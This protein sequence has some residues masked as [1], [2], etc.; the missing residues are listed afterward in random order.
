MVM[1]MMMVRKKIIVISHI[2]RHKPRRLD[3]LVLILNLDE[4]MK[5]R[6]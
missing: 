2:R 5:V 3:F 1:M 6:N 4:R